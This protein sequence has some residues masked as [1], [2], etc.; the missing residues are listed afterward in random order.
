MSKNETLNKNQHNCPEVV[1]EQRKRWNQNH[2][3]RGGAGEAAGKASSLLTVPHQ[4]KGNR[5]GSTR[6]ASCPLACL[7]WL[8]QGTRA[9]GDIFSPALGSQMPGRG[10]GGRACE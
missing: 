2:G 6:W 8:L 7:R 10:R 4:R 3:G 9:I 1:C 5:E